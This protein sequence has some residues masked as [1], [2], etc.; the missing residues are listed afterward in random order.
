MHSPAG[1]KTKWNVPYSV[2]DTADCVFLVSL[3]QNGEYFNV[4]PQLLNAKNAC[5]Y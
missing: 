5:V 4:R 3:A 1:E 2:R